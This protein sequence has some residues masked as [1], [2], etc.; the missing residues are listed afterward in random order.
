M[1]K[2]KRK[3]FKS[4][5]VITFLIMFLGNALLIYT[6]VTG[7]PIFSVIVFILVVFGLFSS[8]GY[9]SASL[10]KYEKPTLYAIIL[11][12]LT[13]VYI[14]DST[15]IVFGIFTVVSATTMVFKTIEKRIG[16]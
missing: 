7:R 2:V 12:T 11:I 3:Y 4:M 10:D 9:F 5:I 14:F 15:K 6:N 8:V 16:Y 1:E 13:L